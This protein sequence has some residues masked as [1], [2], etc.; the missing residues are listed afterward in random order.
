MKSLL[1]F[2]DQLLVEPYQKYVYCSP[3]INQ[4]A[5]ISREHELMSE[6][7]SLAAPYPMEFLPSVPSIDEIYGLVEDETTRVLLFVDDFNEVPE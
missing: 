6:L 5:F 1:R 4:D 2:K 7:K 3:N